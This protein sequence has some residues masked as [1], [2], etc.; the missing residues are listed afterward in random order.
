MTRLLLLLP[1]ALGGCGAAMLAGAQSQGLAIDVG[2][3]CPARAFESLIGQPASVAGYIPAGEV[4][5]RVLGAGEAAGP[6]DPSRVTLRADAAGLITGA[7]C[8]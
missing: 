2:V 4:P 5:I 8:S 3:T 1:L 6:A 7:E